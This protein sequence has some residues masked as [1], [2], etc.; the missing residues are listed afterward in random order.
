MRPASQ[1][2]R[3]AWPKSHARAEMVLGPFAKQ[4]DLDCRGETRLPIK[5]KIW[6]PV[7]T[8]MTVDDTP[9]SRDIPTPFPQTLSERTNLNFFSNKDPRSKLRGIQRKHEFQN[10]PNPLFQRGDLSGH[11]IAELRGIA[12]SG[13]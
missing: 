2:P 12:S 11:P 5:A 9:N 4:K 8:G 7:P 1:G 6:I 3:G 10:P 13:T